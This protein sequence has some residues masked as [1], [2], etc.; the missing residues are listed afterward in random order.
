MLESRRDLLKALA[1]LE[2]ESVSTLTDRKLDLVRANLRS[3][4]AVAQPDWLDAPAVL[5]TDDRDRRGSFFPVT[6][7]DKY[8]QSAQ[9]GLR[10]HW[11]ELRDVTPLYPKEDA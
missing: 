7:S 8:W 2:D 1:L 11:N 5:A 3:A 10:F 9:S 4:L 6:G